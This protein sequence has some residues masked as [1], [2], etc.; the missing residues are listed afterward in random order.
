MLN[1]DEAALFDAL[2]SAVICPLFYTEV[3]ADLEKETP[4]ERSPEKAVQ[5][6]AR[7]TPSMHSTPNVLHSSL[8]LSELSGHPIQLR[9]VPA[10][11]GALQC[12]SRASMG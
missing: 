11:P 1:A 3:L 2:F 9:R 5:D 10:R 7:K 6:L 4:P 8:C 12:G